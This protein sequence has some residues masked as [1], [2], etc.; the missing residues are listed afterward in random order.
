RFFRESFR[1]EDFL[2][3][4]FGFLAAADLGLLPR[5]VSVRPV[6]GISTRRLPP[7]LPERDAMVE[8]VPENSLREGPREA[9]NH[10]G[11]GARTPNTPH[12]GPPKKFP[13]SSKGWLGDKKREN[14]GP[15]KEGQ[16]TSAPNKEG[17]IQ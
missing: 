12:R 15:K 17:L 14:V 10:G 11:I 5:R 2:N 4:F 1:R 3:A 13:Y 6:L 7:P 16:G 9:H 8:P